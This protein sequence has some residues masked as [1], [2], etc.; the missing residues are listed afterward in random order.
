MSGKP[1]MFLVVLSLVGLVWE[2]AMA[3]SPRRIPSDPK[4]LLLDSRIIERAEGVR[5]ALGKVEKDKH[6]PLFREDKPW[7]PRFDN[8][9]ANVLFDEEEGIYKCWY[10]PF[11]ID[12]STTNTPRAKRGQLRYLGKHTGRRREMGVCYATSRDGIAWE[13]PELGLVEFEGSKKNNL[14]VRGPHGSGVMKDP[15]DPDP[16]R[17][18]KMFFK[19]GHMSVAFSADG[20][21]WSKA[22]ACPEMA[23]RG[24]THNNA[25][26]APELGKYVGITRLWKGQRIVGRSESADFLKWT[27]AV[28][29]FKALPNEPRRQTYAMPVFRYANVYLGLVMMIN[30]SDDTVDCELAWSPDT[31]HWE[32]VCPGTP[33]IPRGPKGSADWGCIYAAACPVALDE[34]VTS[35]DSCHFAAKFLRFCLLAPNPLIEERA[36]GPSSGRAQLSKPV[37][38][39]V[40]LAV[41]VHLPSIEELGFTI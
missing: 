13:K 6:N 3:Q 23:A 25:F 21:R 24:D 32:R 16:S 34:P 27:K 17:R 12:E 22:I 33:L 20:V 1:S 37:S 9:Y 2:M 38:R 5:L 26:W 11:I 15:R 28:E 39:E 10:S 19:A 29:V 7:E 36:G 14:V 30:R 18:Y 8:L 31:V 40:F 4:Y 41:D 35:F